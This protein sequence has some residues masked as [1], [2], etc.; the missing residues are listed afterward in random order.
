METT[1]PTRLLEPK[2]HWVKFYYDKADADR[3]VR[4]IE[5]QLVHTQGKHAGTPFKLEW[6]E[7]RAV[8]RF[9][10]WKRRDNG[11]RRYR[12]LFIFV[13]R[14]NGKTALAGAIASYALYADRETAAQVVCAASDKEQA[15]IVFNMVKDAV[16][17]NPLLNGMSQVF[18]TSI[19][20]PRTNSV[21]KVLSK[22][23]NTKHG[24]NTSAAIIDEVH[25]IEDQELVDVITT[26]TI[27]RSQPITVYAST[28]GFDKTHFFYDLYLHAK[29]VQ[30]DPSID[31]TW[32]PLI[33]EADPEKWKDPEEWKRANPNFGVTMDMESFEAD[34]RLAMELPRY[35]NT[36]KRLRLNIWTEQDTRF[37]PM[38]KW[39]PC[40]YPEAT[41]EELRGRDCYVGLDLASTTDFASA[42]FVFPPFGSRE[43]YD[44]M[45]YY[46]FPQANVALRKKRARMDIQPWVTE[47]LINLTS[48]EVIDYEHIRET[49]KQMNRLYRVRE[50]AIDR[51]NAAQLST[52]LDNDGFTVVPFG[53]GFA[54]MSDPTKQ[55]LGLVLARKLNHRNHKVL[56]WN[57]SNVQ[58]EEDAAGNVKPSKKRSKEKIDGI[59][60][61]IMGLSRAMVNQPKVS[62]YNQRGLVT[63]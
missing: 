55:L 16:E 4:F 37:L 6:W 30:A 12:V 2:G 33:F 56:T 1:V 17:A 36:F 7:K 49:I 10:G 45:M 60:A 21:F 42:A 54:S 34:Y 52:Q 63:L 24:G 47:G 32:L 39:Y 5:K 29:R 48:G 25:A 43:F 50:I 58:V 27:A 22:K 41:I 3:A 18:K 13:P 31:E 20:T 9:F 14:K 23:P 19:Y 62:V 26:G 59:V 46:W 51:W 61:V 8:M 53:Q 44:V 28:A 57:A 40:Y 11:R 38:E 15:K 35:E